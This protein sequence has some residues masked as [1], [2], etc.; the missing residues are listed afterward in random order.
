MILGYND[1]SHGFAVFSNICE[2]EYWMEAFKAKYKPQPGQQPFGHEQFDHL[3]GH[4][5]AICDYPANVFGPELV[6]A[7]PDSK[8]VLVERDVDAWYKSFNES[9]IDVLHNP[10]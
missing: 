7:Y 3:L 5:G 8:V 1:V 10:V 9:V 6:E 2:T 4:C